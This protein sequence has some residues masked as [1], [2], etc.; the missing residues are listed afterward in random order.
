[1]EEEKEVKVEKKEKTRRVAKKNKEEKQEK[2]QH[3]VLRVI[4][5]IIFVLIAIF[6]GNTLRK[7]YI[8]NTYAVAVKTY[9]TKDNFYVLERQWAGDT[10]VVMHV[11]RKEA[12]TLFQIEI[13]EEKVLEEYYNCNTKERIIK[14]NN[15][16][17][18]TAK[19]S[20]SDTGYGVMTNISNRLSEGTIG[21]NFLMAIRYAITDEKCNGKQCYK[22]TLDENCSV[23]IDKET[24]LTVKIK[25]GFHRNENGVEKDSNIEYFYEFGIVTDEDVKKPDLTGYKIQRD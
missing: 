1:M 15:E 24:G 7:F 17:E 6:I 10:P 5:I 23:W 9:Q 19:I 3:N 20:Q 4:G 25:N 22:I 13:K 11:Y 18:K 12:E 14:Y 2:K 8:L 16:K 21:E